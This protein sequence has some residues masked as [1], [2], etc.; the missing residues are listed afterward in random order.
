MTSSSDPAASLALPLAL[1]PDIAS[2]LDESVLPE[3]TAVD[4][5][6]AVLSRAS[7]EADDRAPWAGRFGAVI[8]DLEE[9]LRREGRNVSSAGN[10]TSLLRSSA[11]EA[12]RRGDD[13][14]ALA[15]L[16]LAGALDRA[17]YTT[18]LHVHEISRTTVSAH[19]DAAT[20][21]RIARNLPWDPVALAPELAEFGRDMT[22][23]AAANELDPIACRDGH[24]VRLV[25]IL[26]RRT[27]NNPVLVGDPGV[28]KTAIVEGL[29]Q[30]IVAGDVPRLL[31]HRRIIEL[32]MG[33]LIAGAKY[34]GQFEERLQSVLSAVR[35]SGSSIIL[36]IDELHTI[37]GAGAAEGSLDAG[38]M[39]K[40]ALARGLLRTIGATTSHEYRA[41]IAKD[42]ALERRFQP[43]HVEAPDRGSA[44]IM[45]ATLRPRYEEHHD[46]TILPSTLDA[47]V[48]LS[49]RYIPERL[50]PDKAIDLLDEACASRRIRMDRA[51]VAH[52]A[53]TPED[54][55]VVVAQWS[56]IP[57]ARLRTGCGDPLRAIHALTRRCAT[58]IPLINLAS[59]TLRIR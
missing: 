2:S 59:H 6:I 15:H 23:A 29:A 25:H 28:G 40:P 51:G 30:R 18:V 52:D 44:R 47:A 41:H 53:V 45:L 21:P 43:V 19:L 9:H 57:A 37:V 11:H 39:L 5:L 3:L 49:D 54:V 8:L 4:V 14:V 48:D 46:L 12:V 26:S 24:I 58:A 55:A 13:A 27:K 38:N 42:G 7:G 1:A 50:L 16:L 36:F 31:R 34:R 33:R 20:T 35:N 56:G 10:G 17:S 32:D 22:A